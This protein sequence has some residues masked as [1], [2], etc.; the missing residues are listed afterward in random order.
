M[1]QVKPTILVTGG[2]G[3]IGSHVALALQ[4]AGY[5]LV[6]L[7]NLEYGH[8]ELVEDIL[9]VELV[10]GDISDRLLLDKLFTVH[11]IA[12][13]MKCA[14][15]NAVGSSLEEPAKSYSNND[16]CPCTLLETLIDAIDNKLS[17]AYP[18]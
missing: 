13:V 17:F 1:T 10:V 15:Y 18:F 8:R 9:Q 12:S 14:A 5:N 16:S 2:A 6:V 7:D 11:N 4:R 3:Y